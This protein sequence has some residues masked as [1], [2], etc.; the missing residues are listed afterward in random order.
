M[1]Q[2]LVKQ[3]SKGH[4]HITKTKQPYNPTLYVVIVCERDCVVGRVLRSFHSSLS[5]F[6]ISYFNFVNQ[7][8]VR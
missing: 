7:E 4:H 1:S 6:V 2:N 8:N 3:I 5:S